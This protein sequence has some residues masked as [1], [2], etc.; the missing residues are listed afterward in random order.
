MPLVISPTLRRL[1]S[2]VFRTVFRSFFLGRLWGI[3]V[4]VHSTFFILLFFGYQEWARYL[5]LGHWVAFAKAWNVILL[6]CCIFGCVLLHEYG[7]ALTARRFGIGTKDITLLPIGGVA[8]LESIP[9]SPRQE[10]IVA[11]AGPAVNVVIVIILLSIFG[12]SRFVNWEEISQ[13]SGEWVHRLMNQEGLLHSLLWANI[14]MI[15]FN[16]IPA[17]PMDGGR[18]LRALLAMYMDRVKAT[19]IA[20]WIG[21]FLA[22]GLAYW[23]YSNGHY[24]LIFTA[25]FVWIGATQEAESVRYEAKNATPFPPPFTEPPTST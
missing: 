20:S 17:F 16:L 2:K 7:H 12:A 6:I 9:S 19:D 25:L 23:G 5:Y 8:R 11:I 18:V 4:F 3:D 21:R 10:L 22:I 13:H 14:V 1:I 24:L 15:I